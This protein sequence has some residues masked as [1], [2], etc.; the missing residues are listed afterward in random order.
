MVPLRRI[1][2]EVHRRSLWQVLSIYLVGAWLAYQVVL[3]L[4]DGIGLPDWVPGLAFVLFVVGL[5]IVLATAFVN[6]GPP[7][8]RREEPPA[9]MWDETLLPGV[10]HGPAGDRPPAGA[11]GAATA[12]QPDAGHWLTWR[13]SLG[14]GLVAFLMLGAGTTGFMGMR[15]TG[16]GPMGTLLAKQVLEEH[17]AVLLADFR[18]GDRDL[19]TVVTEALRIDLMQTRVIRLVDPA[20]V[21]EGLRMMQHDAAAGLPDSIALQLAQRQGWKAVL[22]GDVATL[23]GSYIVSARLLATADGA[24]LAAFREV[25]RDSTRLIDAVDALAKQIRAKTGESL[26][27]VRAAEPLWKV[28][29][30]SLSALRKYTEAERIAAT[31]GD[32]PRALALLEEAVAEDPEFASAYRKIA[33]L[34][35]NAGVRRQDRLN[36]VRRAYEL[37]DR[38]PELERLHATATYHLQITQDAEAAVNALRAVLAIDPDNETATN[39][40]TVALYRLGRREEAVEILAAAVRRPD[41]TQS[42]FQNLASHQYAL[43]RREEAR[44]VLEEGVRRMPDNVALLRLQPKL[45]FADGDVAGAEARSRELL[46]AVPSASPRT[47]PLYADLRDVLM[48][49]GRLREAERT[50]RQMQQAMQAAGL[51]AE[52]QMAR[53]IPL[54]ARAYLLGERDLALRELRSWLDSGAL[55]DMPPADRPYMA[56][57]WGLATL[58]EIDGALAMLARF[59]REVPAED[60]GGATPLDWARTSVSVRASPD[61]ELIGR[62]R[63]FAQE[64]QCDICGLVEIADAYVALGQPDSALAV[65]RRYLETPSMWRI[66]DDAWDLGRVLNR[67]GELHEARG[68]REQA[69]SAYARLL[70]LWKDADPEFQP[71]LETVR[72]RVRELGGADSP[73]RRQP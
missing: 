24:V 7:S 59:E 32:L 3:G 11:P 43:G 45:L 61:E 54:Q 31:T 13:R 67:I 40:I 4:T 39:N 20:Q 47:I 37:R 69:L 48:A 51:V 15:I 29:T 9:P 38:L 42:H 65:Y 5:P 68:E 35:G 50:G 8:L 57:A 23:G 71:Q 25:A 41:A 49:T 33:V 30:A 27:S 36:A 19:G 64:D 63:R 56:L 52:S 44:L 16:I 53:L 28:S 17:D 73:R 14:A 6:E 21:R 34:L 12:G 62:L 72:R 2:A 46:A 60:R 55:D 10:A 70:D 1:I 18:G 26:R 22:A 58:G 66:S